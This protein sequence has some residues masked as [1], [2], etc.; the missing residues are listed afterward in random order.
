MTGQLCAWACQ[1]RPVAWSSRSPRI[2]RAGPSSACARFRGPMMPPEPRLR[3]LAAD[4]AL[5]RR[6]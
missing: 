5:R 6:T 1:Y 3:R 4:Q 2:P